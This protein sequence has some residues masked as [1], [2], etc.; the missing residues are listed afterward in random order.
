M[1]EAAAAPRVPAPRCVACGAAA[2]PKPCFRKN[3]YAIHRCGQCRMMFVHPRPTKAELARLYTDEYFR[4]GNKYRPGPAPVDSD[5]NRCNDLAKLDILRPHQPR[6][7][8]LDVGCAMGGFL[9]AARERGYEVAGV[10]TS[11]C[12][13]RHAAQVLG[14][15]VANC[16]LIEAGLEADHYDVVT[17]WDVLE[18]VDDPAGVLREAHR[19]LRRG[20]LLALSTA[21]A[22]A[23][24]ARAL[25]RRWQLLTP[26]QH[27]FYFTV[28]S[29]SDLL[30]SCGFQPLEFGHPAK[31]ASVEFILFKARESFGPIAAPL[32]AVAR[33][34]RLGGLHVAV[35]LGDIM[36]CLA[37]KPA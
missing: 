29:L 1:N 26:P 4:R 34:C 18:H 16:D 6:G 21:D 25:G 3:D 5:P 11:E 24:W 23:L 33:V 19:I 22:G 13:A 31:R 30:C 35:N 12:A 9:A 15:P 17:F 10:E 7:R 36:T 28:H 32:Q 2:A 8:L 37:K 20:G 27:L 14:L